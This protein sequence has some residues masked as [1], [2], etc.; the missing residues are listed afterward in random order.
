[1]EKF[2][3]FSTKKRS[4]LD[5][6]VYASFLQGILFFKVQNSFM[7]LIV[8]CLVF[9]AFVTSAP[10][11][12]FRP[13]ALPLLSQS[14]L[15]N[16]YSKYD[17]LN[18]GSATHW[19]GDNVTLTSYARVDGVTYILLG[20]PS[21]SFGNVSVAEQTSL[22]TWAT[23]TVATFT[24]GSVTLKMTFTSPK[25]I[26]DSLLDWELFSRPAHYITWDVS[27]LDK[28]VHDVQ[29][30]FDVGG[31][32]VA[33]NPQSLMK[34]ERTPV[35][36]PGTPNHLTAISAGAAVQAP[37]ASTSDRMSW[38]IAY[39][40]ADV[41]TTS[42]VSLASG[43][44]ENTRSTFINTGA[45]PTADEGGSPQPLCKATGEVTPP[46]GPQIGVDRGGSD[47]PGSPFTLPKDDYN[48]CY[49]ACN[50][51]TNCVAWAY[52]IPN[53][54]GFSSPT[55]WLKNA[56]PPTSAQSCRVSGQQATTQVKTESPLVLSA[57]LSFPQVSSR[58]S[59]SGF[60]TVAVDEI[61]QINFFGE[62]LPPYWRRN[63]PVGD[64]TV[65]PN[66]MLAVAH[67]SYTSVKARCDQFDLDTDGTLAD[68][69]GNKLSTVGQLVYR[70]VYAATALAWVPSKKTVWSFLKEI[71]SCGC[72]QTS[73]VTYPAFPLFLFDSPELTKSQL[74]PHLEYAMNFTSQP[75]PL[76]WAPH[77]LGYWPL[78]NLKYTD[79]E[80]MPLEETSYFLL[81]IAAIAQRQGGDVS[82]L[83]P[84]WPAIQSWYEYLVTLL[85]FPG[86]QLSTDDF[87]GVLYNATNLAI[88]GIAGIAYGYIAEK[89]T[90]DPNIAAESYAIAADYANTMVEY[91]WVEN[92]DSSH[93]M[94]GYAGSEGD[95]GDRN[96]WAMI[97]NALWLRLLG[98]DNLLPNQDY[99]LSQSAKF[100]AA[101]Q[102]HEFGLPLN[103]RATYTK[104]D[105]M[106]FMAATFYT[107][108]TSVKSPQPS[109]LSLDLFEKLYNFANQ[110][111]SRVPLSDWTNTEQATFV[112]FQARPVY[113][114]MWA[115]VLVQQA[116]SLGLGLSQSDPSLQRAHKVFDEVHKKRALSKL[117]KK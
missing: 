68:S 56:A 103:S 107:M 72:L 92:G 50:A 32:L 114:A 49:A 79:Q 36:G 105:W 22:I 2:F 91:A 40:L 71:S 80:N 75:Y 3:V 82:Y 93:F 115:P 106:T 33:N 78:A 74:I 112:G 53:C 10:V 13:P 117:S 69:G 63:L 46:T 90:G 54:D 29:V 101:F 30:Y 44:A 83:K 41:S 19:T 102:M 58:G 11:P 65:F 96:G 116:E 17:K 98:Y 25:I 7:M 84:Y 48:L 8:I 34:W 47:M 16:T 37:L 76:P 113:G 95:G 66:E 20:E 111:T 26:S 60:I 94:L 9:T 86:L 108:G 99:Y 21:F 43:Y 28:R 27:A 67:S 42:G 51:T 15:I 87:D 81:I 5:K 14:P 38:G 55:C 35:T 70:Q 100:Y 73:D 52:A 110:T 77:H 64:A 57:S 12:A 31:D 97:Y 62:D 6:L 109:Q 4:R 104:D 24:A 18:E 61:L 1:M 23:Q 59:S 39:L 88:K 85:P 45:V 89:Y